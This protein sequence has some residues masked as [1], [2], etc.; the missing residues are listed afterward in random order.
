M[1]CAPAALQ[2]AAWGEAGVQR[3][4]EDPFSSGASAHGLGM[5]PGQSN[6]MPSG[7][8]D[9]VTSSQ[10]SLFTRF[11]PDAA[12]DATSALQLKQNLQRLYG[13][14][15]QLNHGSRASLPDILEEG[16][17]LAAAAAAAGPRAAPGG[18]PT[19]S[20][21]PAAGSG[22]NASWPRMKAGSED[23]IF[24][25]E[26]NAAGGSTAALSEQ[27]QQQQQQQSGGGGGGG[28]APG[29]PPLADF[30]LVG[31]MPADVPQSRTLFIRNVDAGISDEE[32]H[33]IFEVRKEVALAL[34]LASVHLHL[35]RL[36]VGGSQ[37]GCW[38][39]LG[40]PGWPV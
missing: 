5:S 7:G 31:Q 33:T 13:S 11:S 37:T 34:G 17:Q 6:A 21:A 29:P 12:L 24:G 10:Q 32:L 28:P 19:R 9:S 38:T 23:D 16:E 4:A 27:Q 22:Q 3:P 14:L 39:W 36:A 25:M 1:D 2:S 26:L 40:R 18:P 30:S 15:G 35:P 20:Q 8:S